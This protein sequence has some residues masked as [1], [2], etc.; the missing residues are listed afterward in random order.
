M[1]LLLLWAAAAVVL[2][3]AAS[4]A[5]VVVTGGRGLAND[6]VAAEVG[7]ADAGGG[8]GGGGGALHGRFCLPNVGEAL[9]RNCVSTWGPT[10]GRDRR[11]GVTGTQNEQ[12]ENSGHNGTK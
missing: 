5:R 11:R 8:G 10:E 1:P 7:D 6:E 3:A 4:A 12:T 2:A 9:E